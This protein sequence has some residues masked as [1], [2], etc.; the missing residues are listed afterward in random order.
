MIFRSDTS[1]FVHFCAKVKCFCSLLCKFSF[2]LLLFIVHLFSICVH[3]CSQM[4]FSIF[5][6]VFFPAEC[7][8]TRIQS[9]KCGADRASLLMLL[10]DALY[11]I[12]QVSSRPAS[13][14]QAVS[15]FSF[16]SSMSHILAPVSFQMSIASIVSSSTG[17]IGRQDSSRAPAVFFSSFSEPQLFPLQLHASPHPGF[18][19]QTAHSGC[20]DDRALFLVNDV[21]IPPVKDGAFCRF[22]HIGNEFSAPVAVG[23]TGNLFI[24]LLK[25]VGIVSPGEDGSIDHARKRKSPA[26]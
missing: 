7:R 17:T 9:L 20:S 21:G 19:R 25:A 6:T 4:D 3:L 15:S 14:A 13:A 23:Q 1:I 10:Q 11:F 18:S 2:S 5:R 12:N 24:Q 26:D 22:C 8:H 16:P